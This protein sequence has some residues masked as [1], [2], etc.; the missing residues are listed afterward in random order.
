MFS[1]GKFFFSFF[2]FGYPDLSLTTQTKFINRTILSTHKQKT[3]KLCPVAVANE[4]VALNDNRK[5]KVRESNL[6]A[7]VHPN[8]FA[9]LCFCF[10]T[11]FL[12]NAV[13]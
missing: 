5:G 2:Y 9:R 8:G 1:G 10:E 12:S 13:F 3:D 4:F 11:I 7:H 6:K